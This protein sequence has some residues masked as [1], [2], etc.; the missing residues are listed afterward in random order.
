MVTAT[1]ISTNKASKV[2]RQLSEEG[3]DIPKP[4]QSAIYK[5]TF[6]EA[7]KLKKEIID[8]LH[9]QKNGL[10]ILMASILKKISIRWLFLKMKELR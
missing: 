1:K 2:C 3:I 10:Y 7:E 8:K 5:A 4:S 6:K 9:I